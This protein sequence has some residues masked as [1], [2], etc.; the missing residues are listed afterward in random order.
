MG[1][2]KTLEIGQDSYK[3]YIMGRFEQSNN[4]HGSLKDIQI[5]VNEKNNLLDIELKK[6]LN[7]EIAVN[8]GSPLKNDNYSEY[9][10]DDF[11]NIIGA[12]KIS[13]PLIDFWPKM[14]PQWDA[15][16]S[17]NDMLFL[18]EA[19]AHITELESSGTGASE[20]SKKLIENSLNDV[21]KYLNVDAK[22]NWTG[23]YYQYTNR[24]AHLYYLRVL[25][26]LDAYLIFVYFLNDASVNG[27]KQINEWENGITKLY[28]AIGLEKNNL[29]SNYIIDVFID[30][31]SL[32][33]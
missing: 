21:K 10:D 13:I 1:L 24:I 33:P 26:K 19:K 25:N 14:G 3:E 30:Y 4:S 31:N 18:V 32:K 27:P 22:Y 2:D 20:D 15:L 29:F 5:L 12:N 23:T 16:G 9:R 11:L 7:K 8:W 17:Y 6:Q 28:Q